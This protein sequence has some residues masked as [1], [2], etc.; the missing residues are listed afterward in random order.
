MGSAATKPVDGSHEPTYDTQIYQTGENAFEPTP[1][2]TWTPAAYNNPTPWYSDGSLKD[3]ETTLQSVAKEVVVPDMRHQ[4]SL[5][6]STFGEAVKPRWNITSF[7]QSEHSLK[8]QEPTRPS[9]SRS[10]FV[11]KISHNLVRSQG[12]RS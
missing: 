1:A 8:P 12:H 9:V 11:F 6:T 3:T 10:I 5:D 4:S 2:Q 7:D